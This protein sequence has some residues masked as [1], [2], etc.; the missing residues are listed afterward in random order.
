MSVD[1]DDVRQRIERDVQDPLRFA[2]AELVVAYHGPFVAQRLE[3]LLG[4][5]RSAGSIV[6]EN[7]RGA[8]LAFPGHLVPDQAI[9]DPE[10]S[11]AGRL[12]TRGLCAI[13]GGSLS[14]VA[15]CLRRG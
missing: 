6:Y 2:A 4:K 1:A 7:H 12:R 11:P 3:R 15:G 10:D 13:V 8:A 14:E 9:R 5:A